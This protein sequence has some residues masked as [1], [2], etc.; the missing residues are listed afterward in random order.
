VLLKTGVIPDLG[1]VSLIVTAVAVV[2][3][4]LF[5]WLVRGTRFRFLFE[6]PRWARIEERPAR[7]LVA[8]E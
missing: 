3:P 2:T 5:Y 4:V 1:T 7:G 8:A 6:R